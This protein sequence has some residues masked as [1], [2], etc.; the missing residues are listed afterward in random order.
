MLHH[1]FKNAAPG[2]DAAIWRG[3]FYK[4]HLRS[5][6]KYL[7]PLILWAILAFFLPKMETLLVIPLALAVWR[8]HQIKLNSLDS[9]SSPATEISDYDASQPAQLRRQWVAQ[10][11]YHSLPFLLIPIY[12][13]LIGYYD[14][15]SWILGD[16]RG[17]LDSPLPMTTNYICILMLPILWY[18]SST[19]KS[20]PFFLF[21]LCIMHQE[22]LF[23][24]S[25]I[26]FLILCEYG[27]ISMLFGM[28]FLLSMGKL[29]QAIHLSEFISYVMPAAILINFAKGYLNSQKFASSASIAVSDQTPSPTPAPVARRR[30]LPDPDRPLELS[31][32]WKENLLLRRLMM[33]PPAPGSSAAIWRG[34]IIRDVIGWNRFTCLFYFLWLSFILSLPS[35]V[36]IIFHSGAFI[37]LLLTMPNPNLGKTEEFIRAQTPTMLKQLHCRILCQLIPL[38]IALFFTCLSLKFSFKYSSDFYFLLYVP[39]MSIFMNAYALFMKNFLW[40]VLIPVLIPTLLM[41]CLTSNSMSFILYDWL[42]HALSLALYIDLIRRA[43]KP[44]QNSP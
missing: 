9:N 21:I 2:S 42:Q 7:I 25:Y 4:E 36:L 17:S 35:H 30:A 27:C 31:S 5:K 20:T 8:L 23:F 44:Y 24:N 41:Q 3:L 11:I 37:W 26:P 40:V 15:N 28:A 32:W 29:G 6:P 33:N 12:S 43:K 39:M 18:S 34:L 22:D 14:L 38:S 19:L 1:L 16:I 13:L 10:T